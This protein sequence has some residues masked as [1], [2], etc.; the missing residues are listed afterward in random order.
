MPV[1]PPPVAGPRAVRRGKFWP[2]E[3]F[4]LFPE[5]HRIASAIAGVSFML[6]QI[7]AGQ[8]HK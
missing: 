1:V 5:R 6:P 8:F 7:A 4:A 2:G 3:S